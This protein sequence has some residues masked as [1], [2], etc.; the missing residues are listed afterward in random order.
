MMMRIFSSL[1]V[2]AFVAA[3]LVA[4][5]PPAEQPAA[6]PPAQQPSE[7]STVIS[8]AGAGAAPRFA[9]PEFIALSNDAETVDA[10]KTISRVL[11]DDLN[12]EREFAL[13]PND[14]VA[15]V[16]AARSLSEIPIA[17]WRELN[18][19]GVIVG[20]VQKTPAGALH[21]EVRL[22]NVQSGQTAF[23]RQYDGAVASK[24]LYA[25]KM[26]DELHQQQRSL[27]GV[28][29]TKLTFS[30]DRDGER[31]AGTVEKRQAKEIYIGD[32]DGENQRRITTGFSLNITPTWSP[33]A[34]SIAYTSYLRTLPNIFVAHI[35]EGTRD[36]LTKNAGNNFL[37]VWSPDGTKI[38]FA[39]TRDGNSEIYVMN[40][41]G[42]SVRRLTNH[43]M[44]D[45]SPTWAP[46]GTQIAFVSDRT[47]TPQVYVIGTDGLGLRQIT[48]ESYADRPTWSPAPYNEI[49]Y[50]ARTGPGND[51]KILELATGQV[52]SLTFGEGSNESPA[53]SPNGRHLAFMS[54][55]AGKSQI[56]TISR[57]GQDLHQITKT[58]NNWQPDWSK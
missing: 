21:V 4:Q 36:E 46:S 57:T 28:A 19:D 1:A 58:G 47:G 31:V 33:D 24:R 50:S 22:V 6:P 23:S 9:V 11:S 42:S 48:H 20:S 40:K 26:A 10:A 56:F 41:D 43:P 17:R 15:T 45:M 55:R 49:A 29:Q 53:F 16:P 7:I 44:S 18:A 27:R 38:A 13:M 32:Y 3:G 51:V 25:H 30:S 5:Q 34:R 12:F 8:G 2:A 35:Y 37:P 52:R 14:V 54:T 39:S